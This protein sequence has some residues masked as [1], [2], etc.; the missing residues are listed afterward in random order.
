MSYQWVE[1]TAELE[2]S[3]EA[4]TEAGIF[5]EAL[6]AFGE[7]L[8]DGELAEIVEREVRFEGRDRAALLVDWL[9]ELVYL[10]ETEGLVPERVLAI[11]LSPDGL[12]ATVAARRG[13]PPHLVKAATYHRLRFE[14]AHDGFRATLVLDV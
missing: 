12:R 1:H 3:L 11:E 14:P 2:L 8:G 9:D 13:E 4:S 5:E 7:L 6:R 10:A